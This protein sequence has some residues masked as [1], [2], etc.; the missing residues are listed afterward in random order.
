M[1][2]VRDDVNTAVLGIHLLNYL[3]SFLKPRSICTVGINNIM[4]PFWEKIGYTVG[5][6]N[7]YYIVNRNI[8]K[9]QLL[10]DF[11]GVYNNDH[12]SRKLNKLV[13]IKKS[14]LQSLS[15][16]FGNL[17]SDKQ[18][19]SK[20]FNYFFN[21]YLCH[22][23]YEYKVYALASQDELQGLIVFRVASHNSN[24]ALRVVDYYGDSKGLVG[25]YEELQ[26][27]LDVYNA[28]YID[29]YNIGIEEKN[30]FLGGFIKRD[31]N[32]QV[33]IPNYFEP[34]EKKNIEIKYAFKC[35]ERDKY[36]ICK[37]DGDQ[38]RPN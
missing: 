20:S 2:K 9:F 32:N 18:I 21:R 26:G 15:S 27:L 19:P 12:S 14:N 29:F 11:D 34:F 10:G 6:L 5:E 28:E 3:I 35:D 31:L 25:V 16:K 24:Y 33:I 37:G 30:L 8:E 4:I 17:F 23:I 1:W 13:K 7:H 38:D 36:Y 22:P